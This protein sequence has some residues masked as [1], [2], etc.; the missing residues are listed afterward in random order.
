[1]GNFYINVKLISKSLSNFYQICNE[2]NELLCQKN[3][4]AIVTI[5]VLFAL[6]KS[7]I[8]IS[9]NKYLAFIL[10]SKIQIQTS[11]LFYQ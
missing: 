4:L 8:Q 3:D 10:I 5:F 9:I 6:Q 7:L 11:I 2:K 1:M